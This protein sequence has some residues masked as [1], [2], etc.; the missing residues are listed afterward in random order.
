MIKTTATKMYL[1]YVNDFVTLSGFAEHYGIS[2][3]SARMLIANGEEAHHSNTVKNISIENGI[4]KWLGEKEKQTKSE[5]LVEFLKIEMQ[6]INVSYANKDFE[7][8]NDGDYR[9]LTDKEAD[10]DVK[11]HIEQTVWAFNADFLAKQ[12]GFHIEVFKALV[13]SDLCENANDAVLSLI[14]CSCGIDRFIEQAVMADGRGHFINQYDG[15]QEKQGE[16]FI[17]RTN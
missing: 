7:T 15:S 11:E 13:E 4:I 12:T 6:E 3:A 17:Y 10:K 2:E 14:E 8:D 5:A 16:Y 1:D 9:V